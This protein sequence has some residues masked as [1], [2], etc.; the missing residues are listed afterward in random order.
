MLKTRHV[1]K[2]SKVAWLGSKSHTIRWPKKAD[3]SPAFYTR[4]GVAHTTLPQRRQRGIRA[5]RKDQ[6]IRREGT[7]PNIGCFST[8]ERSSQPISVLSMKCEDFSGHHATTVF[9]FVNLLARCPKRERVINCQ[10]CRQRMAWRTWQHFRWQSAFLLS[11]Y[12]GLLSIRNDAAPIQN[13][14]VRTPTTRT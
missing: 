9:S 6:I 2:G 7:C 10:E 14:R 11:G 8:Q 12:V 5:L 1:G 13:P 4:G 3:T